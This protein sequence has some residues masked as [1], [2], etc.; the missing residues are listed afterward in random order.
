M[1][2]LGG[3]SWGGD[4]IRLPPECRVGNKNL[5]HSVF[6]GGILHLLE[7]DNLDNIASNVF[8]N[9]ISSDVIF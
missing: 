4:N 9:S 7:S 3:V 6:Y 5:L 2:F 1:W 8:T